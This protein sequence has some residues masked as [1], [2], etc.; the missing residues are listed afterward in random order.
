MRYF[1]PIALLEILVSGSAGASSLL[2]PSQV[3][4]YPSLVFFGEP[5]VRPKPPAASASQAEDPRVVSPSVIAFGDASVEAGNVASIG[6]A[7]KPRARN[8]H[9]PPMVIRGGI[10]GDPFT[11]PAEEQPAAPPQEATAPQTP[12]DPAPPVEPARP[13]PVQPFPSPPNAVRPE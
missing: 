2:Q 4:G 9:L 13:D 12:P 5:D 6:D 7:E 3:P 11:R 1:F 8:P 10:S